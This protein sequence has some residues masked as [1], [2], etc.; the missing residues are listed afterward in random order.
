MRIGL[1]AAGH[2][3]ADV[4]L[5][6]EA[7]RIGF[8]SIWV[9]ES[10]GL[11][12]VSAM[13]WWAAQT[14]TIGLG[15]IVAV[16]DGRTPATMAMTAMAIDQLSGGR[17]TLG[18]GVSGPVVV[19][20]WHGKPFRKPLARTREYVDI[21]RK[22]QARQE[23]V[24]YSGEFFQLPYTGPGSLHLGKPLKSI[25][26]PLRPHQPIFLASEGP[27]AIELAA[28]IADGWTA[29]YVSPRCDAYY[30]ERLNAGFRRRP[31]GLP[32]DF[33]VLAQVHFA[34]DEDVETAADYVRGNIALFVGG[35]GQPGANF[36]YDALARIGFEAEC[37]II[38][39]LWAEGDRRGA[40]ASI[41][42]RMVE[43][44]ALVGPWDKI[45]DEM[46]AWK[47]SCISLMLPMIHGRP[48]DAALLEKLAE[49]VVGD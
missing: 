21:I 49:I 33:E 16:I 43:A 48:L 37:E 15:T 38:A 35:M 46:A 20:G 11:D 42:L 19:E 22:I 44:I 9:A 36:H 29:F 13:A 12:A 27:K 24:A 8:A 45:R 14:A 18:L 34:I 31:A 25:H 30:R 4:A 39:R 47:S 26:R 10:Y 23:P 28:E 3:P 2:A 17:F 1:Y 6:R 32:E 41:P 5:V 7:E 40:A